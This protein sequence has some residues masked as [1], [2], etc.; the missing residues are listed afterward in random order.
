[1]ILKDGK[2]SGKIQY[3]FKRHPLQKK[4][5]HYNREIKIHVYAKR[6]T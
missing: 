5:N 4:E 3:G 6:Q 1:M 2:D